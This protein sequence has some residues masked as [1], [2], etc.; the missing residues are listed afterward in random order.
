MADSEHLHPES[1]AAHAASDDG[2]VCAITFDA[3]DTAQIAAS[4]LR[5]SCGATALFVGTTRN[6]F[7]GKAVVLLRYQ[8]YSALALKS[9]QRILAQTRAA[10]AGEELHCAVHHR[11]GVVPVGEA[12]IVVAVSAPHR[13][14]A[15]V[16][17]ERILEDVKAHTPIWKQEVYAEGGGEAEWKANVVPKV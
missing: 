11:L 12:S 8:A 9:L 15:F 17:C 4:V 13:K 7:Q 3:L 10:A 5:P 6:T 1:V 14:A 2:D 16:A